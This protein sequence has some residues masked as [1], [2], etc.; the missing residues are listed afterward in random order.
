MRKDRREVSKPNN[1]KK[2][3]KQVVSL[4]KEYK[5]K[6]SMTFICAIISTLFTVISPL[7]IGRATT[8]IYDGIT[9]IMNH[10]GSIDFESLY[11]LLL[12]ATVLYV[13]SA[14]FTYL[15]S[16][17]LT[18][19]ST[20]ISY[21]LRKQLIDKVNM[22]AMEEF[23]KNKRGD[24][25]S[26]VTNDVDSLQTGITS[27]FLQFMTAIITLVGVFVM[28]LTI[29]L[30]MTLV[31]VILV[32][33]SFIVISIVVKRS[34]KFYQY[35]LKYKGSVNSQI[36][37]T[38]TG[39]NI[40]RA[41]NQEEES[42]KQFKEDNDKWYSH[43]WKSQFYSSLMGPIMNFI[44]N[45]SYVAIAVLGAF[46]VL[47]K[48]ITVGDILAFFQYIQNFTHPIQQI[49]RVMNIVQTA[50]AATERIFEFLEIEN[51]E[52][53]SIKGI[54]D[55]KDKITFEHVRF[56]YDE[57][58]VIKDLSFT[59][60]KGEKVA[61][62]GHTGAGKSTII[63]L[64]MRFYD[65]KSGD[66]KI[67]GVNINEYDKNSLRSMVGMVLQDTWLFSDT[68]MENIR[69]GNLKATDEEVIEASKIAYSDNFIKQLPEGYN[70][71]LNE[72]TDN[73]SIGQK[74]LLTIAR[75]VLANKKILILDEATSSVDTRTEKL[76]QEAMD[77]LMENKT[78]FI[79]AH[80]LSTI[81]NA[82]K[83]LVMDDGKII[84]EG[85]H[86]EL[87]QISNGYYKS[88]YDQFKIEGGVD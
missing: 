52:N 62:V 36:E 31:T 67:D 77:K 35:Q 37:E 19:I 51:E 61:I 63:K 43:E 56:G 40:I 83:I 49:T 80:R 69:Y 70:T 24:I 1:T 68:I 74:Q 84:E 27:T 21:K 29:N 50:L 71:V 85:K 20:D 42:F 57:N 58:D 5:L 82:D 17:F 28:M 15:Q 45:L 34:Q 26:R 12:V 10:T 47:E 39:Q 18:Q 72:D 87:I 33:I 8:I 38:F 78:S 60:N 65:I 88:L 55:I 30:W 59:A 23:D 16:W 7:L 81:K 48:A 76:I 11:F 46:F 6:L 64:L 41:F 13:V 3:I 73:I 44:S 79:I 22:L 75:T 9:Q 86:S 54:T 66:I 2:S 25:L 32:P 4:L 14:V 53:L